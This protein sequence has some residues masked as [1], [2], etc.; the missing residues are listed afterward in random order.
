MS[1]EYMSGEGLGKGAAHAEH[2]DLPNRPSIASAAASQEGRASCVAPDL[3]E[4]S[5]G[6][7][8]RLATQADLAAN[9]AREADMK[10]R[11]CRVVGHGGS[12]SAPSKE[13]CCPPPPQIPYPQQQRMMRAMALEEG[14]N[15]GT[16]GVTACSPPEGGI[17]NKL[18][19]PFFETVGEDK[20]WAAESEKFFETAGCRPTQPPF[21]DIENM[22][23]CC[24]KGVTVPGAPAA[25]GNGNGNGVQPANG[26]GAAANGNGE[27]KY[28]GFTAKELMIGAAGTAVLVMIL[29]K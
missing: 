11:G 22:A 17:V 13:W 23:I 10:E 21:F 25:N 27:K 14:P 26:N 8:Y 9:A 15:R 7:H 19:Y 3:I 5:G 28:F 24:P 12:R 16:P 29:K 4:F 1:Y 18:H 2:W 20:K 6:L